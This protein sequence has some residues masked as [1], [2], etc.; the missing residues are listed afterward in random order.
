VCVTGVRREPGHH[1][2]TSTN[3][4]RLL[5]RRGTVR[6]L[7]YPRSEHA[8]LDVAWDEPGPHWLMLAP[9]DVVQLRGEN[10]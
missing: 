9:L 4:A 6:H 10:G 8:E 7:Y 3:A 1:L 2:A 5:G